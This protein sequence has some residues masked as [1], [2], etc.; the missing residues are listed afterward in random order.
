MMLKKLIPPKQW[1]PVVIALLGAIVGLTLYIAQTARVTSYLSDDPETCVNCH[2][3]TPQFESWKHS[4]HRE[5]ATCN[6]CHVPHDNVVSKYAFKAKDGLYHSYMYTLRMEP[7]VI[8]MHQP[9]REVVQANCVRCHND[10]VTDAKMSSWVA[11]H[12]HDRT[13]RACWECHREVPHGRVKSLSSVGYQIQSLPV[14]GEKKDVIPTWLK[15]ALKN[16]KK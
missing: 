15:D 16:K 14:Q 13:D 11:N 12:S 10:Q 5:V 4:S 8:K 6:D 2:V 3:M 7:Q 9:G 1:Q